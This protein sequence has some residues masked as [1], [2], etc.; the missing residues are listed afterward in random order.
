MI[1]RW[2]DSVGLPQSDADDVTQ[3]IMLKLHQEMQ[4][5]FKYDPKKSFRAWLCTVS[6]NTARNHLRG[7]G[8]H[9]LAELVDAVDSG[10]EATED[11]FSKDVFSSLV[12]DGLLK[13]LEDEFKPTSI[14]AFIKCKRDGLSAQQAGA[15]VGISEAAVRQA[16]FRIWKR[17]LILAAGMLD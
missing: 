11:V 15:A 14:E 10:S 2:T 1:V 3:D 17:L 12:L 9:Q 16:I 7:A 13:Q 8:K 5:G 6:R 4:A